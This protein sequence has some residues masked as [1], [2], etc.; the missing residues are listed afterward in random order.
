MT[1]LRSSSPAITTNSMVPAPLCLRRPL[2]RPLCLRATVARK[3]LTQVADRVPVDFLMPD[4]SLLTKHASRRR[5]PDWPALRFVRPDDVFE[6]IAHHPKIG[7]GEA[8]MAGDWVAEE[9]TDLADALRPFAERMTTAVPPGLLKL[10]RLVDR[11]LP[12]H[13]RNS[14]DGSKRNIEAHYDLSHDLFGAFLDETMSYSSALFEEERP[15]AEQEL[16]EAQIAKVHRVLDLASVGEGSE[17]LEIGS[18]WGT[19]AI[20]AAKR[21][22]KVRTITLSQEQAALARQRI[23][24]EGLTHAVDVVIED[25]RDVMGTFD[26]VVSVEMIEAVGEEYWP[27]YFATIDRVLRPEGVAVLQAIIMSDDRLLATRNSF[28]WIQKWIFPGGL[29]PSLE[30][31]ERSCAGLAIRPTRAD[32]FGL[33][34]AETL[35]RWRHRFMDDWP[36]IS[37]QGFTEEFQRMW[38]FYLAY[39]E[40]GFGVGYLDVAHVVLPKERRIAT[41][42]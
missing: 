13:Q 36:E 5:N 40:A 19:L 11:A 6:R 33:H 12:H 35:N 28:G 26:A 24:A 37:A 15:W 10:R 2:L 29:I 7:I 3:V 1:L 38:E 8:Y 23:E 30:A 21:G 22:A 41:T 16:A 39:C 18:G 27:T 14:L 42:S 25:Y 20:E 4:G 9:G 31:I 34:Y 17:V 32:R